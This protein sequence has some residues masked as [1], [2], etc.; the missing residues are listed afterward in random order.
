MDRYTAEH[1]LGLTGTYTKRDYRKAS[2]AALANA[3]LDRGGDPAVFKELTEADKVIKDAFAAQGTDSLTALDA[4]EEHEA[5]AASQEP[6]SATGSSAS[7]GGGGGASSNFWDWKREERERKARERREREERERREREERERK[8]RERREREEREREEREERKKKNYARFEADG[9]FAASRDKLA[10]EAKRRARAE[11]DRPRGPAA[12]ERAAKA[13][14]RYVLS[15]LPCVIFLLMT[16]TR[17]RAYRASFPEFG[18][19]MIVFAV[20]GAALA[21]LEYLYEKKNG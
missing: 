2:K 12:A 5:Q 8:E 6:P 1:L 13:L 11:V 18:N 10:D 4:P 16:G 7:S 19:L 15:V 3:H 20:L 14:R 9:R 21:A 17:S